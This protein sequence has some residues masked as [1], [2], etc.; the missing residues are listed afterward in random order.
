MKLA[1]TT[2]KEG[3]GTEAQLPPLQESSRD[4]CPAPNQGPQT[5]RRETAEDEASQIERE[6]QAFHQKALE[7]PLYECCSVG[8]KK[9]ARSSTNF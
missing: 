8:V 5:K 7:G 9:M 1:K 3:C 4:S 6:N 2:S